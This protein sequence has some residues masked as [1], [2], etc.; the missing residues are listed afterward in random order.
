MSLIQNIKT[1]RHDDLINEGSRITLTG[2]LTSGTDHVVLSSSSS[3]FVIVTGYHLSTNASGSILVSIGLKTGSD[4][5]TDIFQ[6]Y[7][8]NSVVGSRTLSF[9]DWIYGDLEYDLVITVPSDT[10]AYTI[11][12]RV[13]SSPA[14]LGY[15]QQIG[16][17]EH[18]NPYFGLESGA[19]RG[20][21]EF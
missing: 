9:G 1:R 18:A 19:A 17:Q 10:V 5:T 7:I 13:S 20:Q 2:T 21:M 16:S 15:I 4:P 8:G 3:R 12:G 11:D 6:G 14:A